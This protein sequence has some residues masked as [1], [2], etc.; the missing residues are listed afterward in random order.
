VYVTHY[1]GRPNLVGDL[2]GICR[3]RNIKVI[4]DCAL[5][6]FS[7]TTGCAGDAAIFSLRKSLPVSDG[8]VLLLRD[9]DC[10]G[11]G[12]TERPATGPIVRSVLSLV[13]KWSQSSIWPPAAGHREGA[14]MRRGS[15]L[16]DLPASY[17]WPPGAV[18]FGASRFALGL[19][20]RTDPNEVIRRRRENYLH[21]RG[22][23]SGASGL[24]LLWKEDLLEDGLCPLGLPVLVDDRRRWWRDLNAAGVAVSCWWEGYHRGLDWSGFPEAR[25]LK[26]HLLLL[27]VHQGLTGRHMDYIADVVHSLSVSYGLPGTDS[28]ERDRYSLRIQNS[29]RSD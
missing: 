21:L 12:L 23:V 14:E 27:P 17:Y 16:P 1:F 29:V 22:R 15:S 9:L 2:V 7:K 13:K 28:S 10:A 19:L 26:D 5:S 25:T 11:T 3:Q 24:S 6:L 4:E 20:A 18:A 8:G